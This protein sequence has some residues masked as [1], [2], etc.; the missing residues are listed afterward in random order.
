MLTSWDLFGNLFQKEKVICCSMVSER[1]TR[2]Q[3]ASLDI[4]ANRIQDI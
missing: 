3:Q 1:K 4:K 2:A